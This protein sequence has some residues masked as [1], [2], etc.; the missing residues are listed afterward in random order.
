MTSIERATAAGPRPAAFFDRDGVLN[1]DLGYTYRLEDLVLMPGAAEAVRL[2]NAAGYWV[3]IVSNQAG[4]AHGRY[5]EAAALAFNEAVVRALAAQGARVDDVRYCPH[6]PEGVVNAYRRV[7]DCRKPSPGMILD[8]LHAWPVDTAR[9]FLIGDKE[10]DVAAGRAVGIA[11]YRYVGG[12]LSELV[13]DH[14]ATRA[15]PT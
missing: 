7:C 13:L 14:F 2:C 11:S 6:H 9:S 1:R 15:A 12:S 3:F 8:L 10:S 4:V 5:T